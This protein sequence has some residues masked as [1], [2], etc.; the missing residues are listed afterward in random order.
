VGV[1]SFGII[2]TTEKEL[3]EALEMGIDWSIRQGYSWPEDKEHCEEYGR[4]L[5]ADATKVSKR[6]KKT[7][8]T[9]NG[10][11]GSWKPLYR[12]S[13]CNFL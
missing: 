1:G 6:A 12:N 13:K 9:T 11:F 4:M 7:R 3:M 5:T 10:D 8:I 2:P